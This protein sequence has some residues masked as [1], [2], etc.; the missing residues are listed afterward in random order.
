MV[1]RGGP[2]LLV[3]SYERDQ[4][5]ATMALRSTNSGSMLARLALPVAA[6]GWA[7]AAEAKP[8]YEVW[9][10]DQSDS[11]GKGYGGNAYVFQ[12]KDLEG[13]DPGNAPAE[14]IDLSA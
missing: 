6:L 5:E 12:G 14:H 8:R 11:T 9:L 4:E 3:R 10:V 13:R 1:A 2:R 7:N